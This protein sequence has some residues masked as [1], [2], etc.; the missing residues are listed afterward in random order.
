MANRSPT[1]SALWHLRGLALFTL[2]P[3]IGLVLVD[4]IFGLPPALR[5]QAGGMGLFM[6]GLYLYLILKERAALIRS[7]MTDSL[8][9][10]RN[11]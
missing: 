5:W 1:L 7:A 3:V 10:D 11:T 4:L 2:G 6:A 8:P 9:P